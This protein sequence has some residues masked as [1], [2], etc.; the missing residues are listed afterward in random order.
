MSDMQRSGGWVVVGL[1]RPCQ[2]DEGLDCV[3]WVHGPFP[4]SREAREYAGK[5]PEG[6]RPHIMLVDTPMDTS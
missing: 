5:T 2:D 3:C 1:S 4:S 6:F